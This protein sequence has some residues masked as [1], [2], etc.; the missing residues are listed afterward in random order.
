MNSATIK[1]KIIEL[2][3]KKGKCSV[4][5]MKEYLETT[6]DRTFTEGQLSG[7]INTLLRNNLIK[8]IERGSY[9]LVEQQ[10]NKECFV[11]SPIGDE[12][13][14]IRKRADQLFKYIIQPVCE[15][16]K[17]TPIRADQIN[18]SDYINQT[19]LDHLNKDALVIADLTDHNPNVFYEMGYR[20][21]SKKPIIHLK[22]VNESIPFDVSS[23]RTFDYDLSDLDSVDRIKERLIK[24]INNMVFLEDTPEEEPVQNS[25]LISMLGEILYK[26]EDIE[27]KIQKNNADTIQSIIKACN[28]SKPQPKAESVEDMMTRMLFETIINNPSSADSLI[29]LADKFGNQNG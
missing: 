18:D 21:S 19:V 16:C 6:D 14:E 25:N 8:K 13:S 23:V 28:E 2:I 24:T 15:E 3:S 22:Q 10:S 4:Q 26:V 27:A 9:V 7:S 29:A 20:V 5:E 1:E 12:R 17:L 11:I